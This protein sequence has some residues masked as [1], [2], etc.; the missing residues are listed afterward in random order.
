MFNWL[1]RHQ[2]IKA[3]PPQLT[4][5]DLAALGLIPVLDPQTLLQPRSKVIAE[6]HR[7]LALPDS[8]TSDLVT[9]ALQSF[10]AL[11]QLLPASESHHHA[12]QGGMLDHTLAVAV[13]ALKI[14]AGFMLP[15]GCAPEAA[16]GRRILWSYA[17]FTAALLHDIGKP[18]GDQDIMLFDADG[19]PVGAWNPWLDTMVDHPRARAYKIT[20]RRGRRHKA[21]ERL[22][23]L[24]A[25]RILPRAALGWIGSDPELLPLW[26]AA[27][28]GDLGSAGALGEIIERADGQ[29]TAQALGAAV[30]ATSPAAAN[31]VIPLHERMLTTLRQLIDE[32][33]LP[34]G[35]N[36]DNAS[37]WLAGDVVWMVSKTVADTLREEMRSSGHKG[38]PEDNN[39]IFDV[40]QQGGVLIPTPDG[41]AIWRVTVLTTAGKSNDMSVIAIPVAAI[42]PSS[43]ARPA[44]YA[45]RITM[46]D[47]AALP[48]PDVRAESERINNPIEPEGSPIHAVQELKQEVGDVPLPLPPLPLPSPATA[49]IDNGVVPGID[50]YFEPSAG[51]MNDLDPDTGLGIPVT[52]TTFTATVGLAAIAA[53]PRALVA[54]ESQ[55][56]GGNEEESGGQ[57]FLSWL[58]DE[59][60]NSRVSVNA[61]NARV[62][63]VQEGVLL[64]SP[65]VFRDYVRAHPE[66][67]TYEQAQRRFQRLGLH[68]KAGDGTNIF[69]Y[70]VQG[71]RKAGAVL[72]GYLIENHGVVFGNREPPVNSFLVR[73]SSL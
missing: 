39:R 61:V 22:G 27:I 56:S 67:G 37:A 43:D 9:S 10:A 69:T 71:P 5:A 38:V 25:H 34:R 26:A 15:P 45:G 14:R 23:G 58:R 8:Q 4:P 33:R 18:V 65:G 24:L 2:P 53:Q 30:A 46:R 29:S 6:I 13:A 44:P 47:G 31:R 59:I 52:T 73:Q 48:Q 57:R 28:S 21:H 62:H 12:G 3:S 68:R 20:F 54:A 63:R 55:D 19:I 36:N 50:S 60:S 70:E 35:F 32:Q 7:L 41:R 1:R 66:E 49:E 17:V 51:V 16:G 40:L 11:V 72:K 42:W 64:V